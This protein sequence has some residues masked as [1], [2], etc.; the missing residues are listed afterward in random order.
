MKYLI[1]LVSF[2]LLFSA[3]SEDDKDSKEN[4]DSSKVENNE[5]KFKDTLAADTEPLIEA[6]TSSTDI[7][8][9]I[10][11]LGVGPVKVGELL[12]ASDIPEY[13]ILESQETDLGEGETGIIKLLKTKDGGK[14]LLSFTQDC[15]EGEN[16]V[17][18]QIFVSDPN[19]K[20]SS[21]IGVGSTVNDF[22]KYYT[23]AMVIGNEY[24]NVYMYSE[25]VP[26]IGFEVLGIPDVY[27]GK[28]FS[29]EDVPGESLISKVYLYNPI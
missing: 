21:G 24:G 19:F 7:D 4:D 9:L 6:Q 17:T 15:S 13:Y 3:C 12:E 22:K 28:E 16:C 29:I 18:D 11:D 14:L 23:P 10:D 5:E 8:Y 26:N 2:S 20:T 27:P 1:Y 25:E